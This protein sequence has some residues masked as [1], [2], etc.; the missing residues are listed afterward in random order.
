MNIFNSLGSNYNLDLVLNT[1][2]SEGNLKSMDRLT[3]LLTQKFGGEALLLYK[4]REA[5]E[6]SL[7]L[8]KLS[9]DDKVAICGYTCYAVYK[10]VVNVGMTPIFIDIDDGL[11]FSAEAL[12]KKLKQ[13]EK[14][15]AV[16]IQNTLG[17]PCDI[18]GIKSVVERNDLILIEDLAHSVGVKYSSGQLAGTV[19][20]FVILTFSQDKLIDGVSGGALIVRNKKY[21]SEKIEMNYISVKQA[22]IDKLYPLMT[23]SIRKLYPYFGIGKTLHYL[24]KK[25]RI[26]SNPMTY[27]DSNSLHVLS[28]WYTVVVLRELEDLERNISHRKKIAN[29]YSNKLNKKLLISEVLKSLDNSSNLRFPLLVENR[30]SLINFLKKSGIY[31]SDIWYDAP[32]APHKYMDKVKYDNSCKR[33]EEV[34]KKMLNLPTHK[35]VSEKEAEYISELV[36]LWLQKQL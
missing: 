10:A 36:N 30:Q 19:G 8:S 18:K 5:I 27:A 7:R 24:L 15:K 16:I 11:N 20:D 4:G 21:Y 2:F 34:S 33:S 23:F 26:L 29:V 22:I 9:K 25:I 14:I 35:N 17:Y 31:V 28:G 1:L 6:L 3:D 32:V 12:S 13:E